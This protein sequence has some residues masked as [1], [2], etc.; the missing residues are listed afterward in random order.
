M[1]NIS[2]EPVAGNPVASPLEWAHWLAS[3]GFHVLPLNPET[4]LPYSNFEVAKVAGVPVPSEGEGGLKLATT[5]ERIIRAWWSRW[6]AAKIGMR[7]GS[8][9]GLYVLDID[10]KNGKDGFATITA[11]GW[12]IPPTAAV[13]TPSGGAHYFFRIPQDA[14]RRWK[15][16]TG[17]IG[18]G[19]D[20]KGDGGFVVWYG[21]DLSQPLATPPEWMIDQSGPS[22]HR[23]PLGT[24]TAPTFAHATKALLSID[25][26]DDYDDWRDITAAYRQSATAIGVDDPTIRQVW[27]GWCA[28]SEKNDAGDNEKL[29]RSL[30]NGTALGWHYLCSRTP[31]HI[32]A[33]LI[34]GTPDQPDQS[35]L[36]FRASELSGPPPSREW[37]VQDMIPAHNVTLLGGDGGTGKSLLALQLAVAVAAGRFWLNSLPLGG[38]ALFISAED[39]TA[40]LH[41]RLSAIAGTE[42][43]ALDNLR[44]L[45]LASLAGVNALLATLTKTGILQPT[46]LY[47]S[48]DA[49]IA[50]ERPKL[51]VLDTLA[52]LYPGNENDRAQARQFI[53]LLR[54]LAIH[55]QC[56]VLLLAHPSLSGMATGAGTSGSTGW[57]NSVRSRLYFERIKDGEYEPNVDARRIKIMKSNYGRIGAE[58]DVTYRN[59]VFIAN[60]NFGSHD[61]NAKAERVFLKLL[62]MYADQGREVNPN[63]GPNYAPSQFCNHPEAE[64]CSKKSLKDAMERLL[65]L[66]KI[67]IKSRQDR[68]H[69]RNYIYINP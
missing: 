5:D 62:K 46:P 21:A 56:A 18:S 40:E 28:Q 6:P 29:W 23:K 13:Q 24:E 27:E 7:T 48:I 45:T 53:G 59:G 60:Q 20:R 22:N 65:F 44:Q 14:S 30:A 1:S 55:H 26:P 43:I 64:G 66:H 61:A 41:R 31:P 12:T 54:R 34:F 3:G 52:D 57:N 25:P 69:S 4:K 10:R 39:D 58:I 36:F 16:D 33:E 47:Q 51:V 11:N 9:S 17:E 49:K 67:S 50:T 19:L 15:T 42:N 8:I 35:A 38:P 63:A 68:G 32:Q 37:L 2:P